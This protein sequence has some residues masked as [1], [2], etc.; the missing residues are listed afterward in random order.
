MI[1]ID[2]LCAA[3]VLVSGMRAINNMTRATSIGMRLSWISL[4]TGALGILAAPLFGYLN[5]G[6]WLTLLHV[7]IC[8]HVVFD[9]RR[10]MQ[11]ATR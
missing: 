7:G 3:I 1:Y 9:K 6:L 11:G 5:S 4:T 10:V 8:L 2:L